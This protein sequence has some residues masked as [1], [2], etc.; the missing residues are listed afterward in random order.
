MD[1]RAAQ[2]AQVGQDESTELLEELARSY[3]EIHLLHGLAGALEDDIE[4]RHIFSRIVTCLKELIP[5]EKA[6]VWVLH[7]QSNEY[8]CVLEW[9]EGQASAKLEC[10]PSPEGI[11][12]ELCAMGVR[13]IRRAQT[14]R[15]PLESFL[16]RISEAIGLPTVVA[17]LVSKSKL[18]GLLVVKLASTAETLDSSRLRLVEAAARQTR[19]SM[20]LDF[21]IRELRESERLKKEV[22][23]ARQIQ[24]GL[25]PEIIPKSKAFEVFAS[26][27]TAAR[28]GGDYYDLF[29]GKP[30]QLSLLIADVAGHNIA[31]ALIA[32]SFR[33]TFRFYLA[34]DLDHGRLFE[35]LNEALVAELSKSGTFLS[36]FYGTYDELTRLFR[37][38]NAGHNPPVLWKE[39]EKRFERLEHADLLIGILPGQTFSAAEV[40]I[41]PGDVLILYTD[42]IVEAENQNGEL[43][44]LERLEAA[45]RKNVTRRPREMY[46]YILKEMYLFQDEQFNKD[47]VTLIVLRATN[48]S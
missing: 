35:S 37:Y 41:D 15:G 18:V 17:P 19:V 22:E 5:V 23:I 26:C 31:S 25:L 2:P 42:G 44:G 36:A 10:L 9:E 39:A 12:A 11:E 46:H 45:V 48:I 27:I 20:Q 3:E 21:L 29:C 32:M 43:F 6:A 4:H 33:T 34:Q 8:S 24:R 47:D 7:A 16:I 13:V 1:I 40:R 38:V 28:V 30:G 14:F